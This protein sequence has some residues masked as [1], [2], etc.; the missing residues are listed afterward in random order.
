[1]ADRYATRVG[2]EMVAEWVAEEDAIYCEYSE[3]WTFEPCV[4]VIIN[5]H[6]DEQMWRE[7][8]FSDHGFVCRIDGQKYSNEL[9]VYDDGI[10]EPR[11][12]VNEIEQEE[13]EQ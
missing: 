9:A 11:A 4:S 7:S 12:S 6:G 3:E 5:D 8:L 13:N 2:G 1:M 10:D